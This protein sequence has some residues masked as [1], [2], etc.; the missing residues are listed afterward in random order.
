MA[1]FDTSGLDELVKEMTKMGQ[2][3]GPLAECMV[4]SAVVV[5]RDCWKETAEKHR[6]HDT[7]DM[8][9]SIGF[10]EPVRHIGS[11]LAR[12]VYPQGKD[13]NGTRNAEKAFLLHYGTTSHGATRIEASHW[14]DEADEKSGPL[15]QERLEEI[16]NQF[17]E[18]GGVVPP[19]QDTGGLVHNK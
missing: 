4:N 9:K 2:Q 10:P 14:V 16:W 1:R 12:D 15:V 6:F 5:I 8:I 7:G 19:V 18:S 11:A 3:S 13:R 17:L